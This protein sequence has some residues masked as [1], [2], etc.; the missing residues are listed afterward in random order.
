MFLNHVV[1]KTYVLATSWFNLCCVHSSVRRGN[2]SWTSPKPHP[3]TVRWTVMWPQACPSS[4]QPNTKPHIPRTTS[5]P[6][7]IHSRLSY[8]VRCKTNT[9][10]KPIP[11]NTNVTSR[12]R[13]TTFT[14]IGIIRKSETFLCENALSGKYRNSNNNHSDKKYLYFPIRIS[15][16]GFHSIR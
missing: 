13:P 12:W 7:P 10:E 4:R 5:S 2:D 11:E 9:A 16:I 8:T 15:D 3:N 6:E 1:T 14:T